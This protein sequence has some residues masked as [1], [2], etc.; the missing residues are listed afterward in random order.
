MPPAGAHHCNAKGRAHGGGDRPGPRHARRVRGA[1]GRDRGPHRL[2]AARAD[3]R[4]RHHPPP[5]QVRHGA[6]PRRA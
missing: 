3:V 2:G 5:P 4:R 6:R 1:R